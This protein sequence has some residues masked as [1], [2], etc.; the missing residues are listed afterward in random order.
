MPVSFFLFFF[1][2]FDL[3]QSQCC[4][5]FG[6]WSHGHSNL[7]LHIEFLK[8]SFFSLGI[9]NKTFKQFYLAIILYL[10]ILITMSP[11]LITFFYRITVFVLNDVLLYP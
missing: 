11:S 9:Y 1:F 8:K 7:T 6:H 4:F 3:C 2:F 5:F 10:K